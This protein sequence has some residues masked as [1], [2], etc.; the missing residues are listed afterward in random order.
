M[1]AVLETWL[2]F[3]RAHT[4]MTATRLG[5]FDAIGDGLLGH[6]EVARRCG[7]DSRA[8]DG[9]LRALASTGF[10]TIENERYR[11]NENSRGLVSGPGSVRDK[12]TFMELEQEWWNRC[13]DYVRSGVPLDIHG[14]LDAARWGLY[15]RGMRAGKETAAAEVAALLNLADDARVGLD[16]GGG[17]GA[18]AVALCRRYPSLRATIVDLPQAIEQA[19]P[20][21]AAEGLGDRVQHRA[22]DARVAELGEPDVVVMASLVHH[23]DAASN[24]ALVRRIAT[25]LRPRGKLAIVEVLR[26]S[27]PAGGLLD[28]Y[29]AMTSESGTWTMDEISSW[30]ADAGLAIRHQVRLASFAAV[31][32]V[33]GERV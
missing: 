28:L 32:V 4:L 29:F 10:L 16:I 33:V 19:A 30:Y 1:R 11:L 14:T 15:Q 8:T 24:R 12:V 18:Y 27:G 9:L 2:G 5:V 3:L 26:D 21:L 17:H 23:F 20:L 6:D 31:G 25:A 7:T 13:D 22:G